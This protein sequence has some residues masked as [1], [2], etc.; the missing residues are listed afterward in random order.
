LPWP[1]ARCT[2]WGHWSSLDSPTWLGVS[3]LQVGYNANGSLQVFGVGLTYI[4]RWSTNVLCMNTQTAPNAATFSGWQNL[5]RPHDKVFLAIR[6]F[7]LRLFP[8]KG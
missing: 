6:D 2:I 3:L 7:F 1:F 5:G 4:G 8:E